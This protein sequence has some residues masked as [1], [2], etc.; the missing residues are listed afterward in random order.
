[1]TASESPQ[2]G[3]ARLDSL[4]IQ[5]F[6]LFLDEEFRLHPEVTVLIGRNDTGKSTVLAALELYAQI[7]L[8]G[9]FRAILDETSNIGKSNAPTVLEARWLVDGQQ[10]THR[11]ELDPK[12]P[13]EHLTLSDNHKM[14]TWH[15]RERE[16][17]T[18]FSAE[19]KA[20]DLPRYVSLARVDEKA[21]AT[22][23]D[24]PP[25]VYEPLRVIQR[26]RVP[27]PFLFQWAALA[28]PSDLSSEPDN[29]GF[30]WAVWLQD[31]INRRDN[32]M[33]QLEERL[34]TLF[35][36]FVNVRV[37]EEKVEI[38]RK[39][40]VIGGDDS[41]PK[42][43]IKRRRPIELVE[44][45]AKDSSSRAVLI[46]IGPISEEAPSERKVREWVPA[47]NVSSGLLLALA[48]LALASVTNEGT[49]LLIEEPE[50]GLNHQIMFSV[51]KL[52]CEITKSR[53]QQLVLTT[54]NGTWLDI[55]PIES[56]RVCTRDESGAHIR[57]TDSAR[58]HDSLKKEGVY[59]SELFYAFGPEALLSNP[60][61]EVK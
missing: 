8:V 44:R 59:A 6:R 53:R 20:H 43:E 51:V 3:V 52:L 2:T 40:N 41:I 61:V 45:I 57:E 42:P 22:E 56:V 46:G 12:K 23:T 7:S 50:N 32:S 54:H 26:F 29:S 10:W 24:V 13:L 48:H 58:V 15:P 17:S 14:W 19:F 11:L 18:N 4:R 33:E 5:N 30:G 38:S 47:K 39:Q 55:V 37:H 28:S 27:T 25:D 49:L 34:R 36:S 1:M 9:G 21:W 35:P 31:L 16:L 60:S